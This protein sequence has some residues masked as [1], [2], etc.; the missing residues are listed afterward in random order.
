MCSARQ[1]AM[2]ARR[3]S[4]AS[5]GRA[6]SPVNDFWDRFKLVAPADE[7]VHCIAYGSNLSVARMKSRCPGAEV[8]GTSMLGGYRLLFKK[9]MTGFY[10]TIEQDANCCVPVVIYRMTAEDE[11]RLD[12]FEGYPKY[13]YK[14]EFLL[15]VWSLK[16]RRL[17]KRRE[18][19]AYIMHEKRLLG[20]PT[21]GYYRL[22]DEGYEYWGFEKTYLEN[23]LKSSIGN[24]AAKEWLEAYRRECK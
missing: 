13:Y 24:K 19:I 23:G 15:P 11:A 12:R 14:R 8:I 21:Q 22:L 3:T 1:T 4:T 6:V 16:G 7:E 2:T 18:C 10:A 20:E 5:S 9:S 17:K